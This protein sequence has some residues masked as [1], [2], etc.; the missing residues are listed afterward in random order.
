MNIISLN[1][2]S[3]YFSQQS[4]AAINKVSYDM[5][6][7][8]FI[9][10]LG[11]NGA[12]KST[13]LKLLQGLHRQSEGDLHLL[14]KPLQHYPS[15]ILANHI[16]TL[17]QYCNDSLFTSL[18]IYENYTLIAKDKSANRH[19]CR[20]YLA[21]FNEKLCEKLDQTVSLLSGGEK[22][23]F[24][25]ALCLL[26]PPKLLL[27]DEHTSALDPK[28][29]DHIMQLTERQVR[30]HQITCMLTTHNLDHA[31]TYGNRI[32]IMKEGKVAKAYDHIDKTELTRDIL[33][34]HY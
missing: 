11:S 9:V 15:R 18:T 10:L 28:T 25:L 19:T 2:I 12:G 22:Q 4:N 17:T 31:L 24:A 20:T 32:L 5:I 13:L 26:N 14:N 21:E 30:K 6:A 34:K 29:A 7:G 3:L 8:D 23:A 16:S 27:L 1:N 33:L